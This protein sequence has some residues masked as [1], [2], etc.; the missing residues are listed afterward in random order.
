MNNMKL[1]QTMKHKVKDFI[2]YRK[3]NWKILVGAFFSGALVFYI[4]IIG[5]IY[6]FD[7]QEISPQAVSAIPEQ[8]TET[9]EISSLRI[10]FTTDWEYGY[11]KR[12]KHKLTL[13][14]LS[15]LEEAVTYLNNVFHPDIVVGG[16]DYIESTGVKPERAKEQLS[17]I[18]AVFQKLSA[19]RL[20]ALG[21]HDLR[22][23]TKA[24]VREVL[25]LE[26]NH[27]FR[28]IGDWRLVVLDTNFN[29]DGSDRGAKQYVTGFASDA[30]LEW[31]ASALQTER[32]V[33]VFS[34]HSPVMSPS[35]SGV[36]SV[37][38]V[39]AAAVRRVL[40]K[41]GNVVG[42]ISGHSP[43]GYAEER[44]GIHYFVVDT[45]V[46]EPVLGTFAT[47]ELRYAKEIREAEILFRRVGG[48]QRSFQVVDRKLDTLENEQD[49]L[50]EL[51]PDEVLLPTA[52]D[53]QNTEA[54]Y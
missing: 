37:N 39:N 50:P 48:K 30:E 44:N 23:L 33:L 47:L 21:N 41:A 16:G 32:P 14:A 6:F 29:K 25:G 49:G 13:Q 19:P 10:G 3:Y 11:R 40:E 5:W 38:I 4:G 12:M 34:H 20:Y 43:Y 53:D 24:D 46:N 31:L 15:A 22:S 54:E 7:K 27:T 35:A 51:F 17:Q 8:K 36:F 28:D 1:L 2:K 45:L 9:V 26:D 52:D 42:V 18:N